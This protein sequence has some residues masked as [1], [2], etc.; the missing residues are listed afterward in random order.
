MSSGTLTSRAKPGGD[1]RVKV[2]SD[3][4]LKPEATSRDGG[5]R[6][7]HLFVLM[8]LVAATASVMLSRQP[9]PAN[10]ILV[11]LTVMAAGLAGLGFYRTLAPLVSDGIAAGGEALGERSRAVLE[12]EKVLVLRSIKELEFDRAMGKVSARDFDE[13]AGRLRARAI[14]L[15]GQL[16]RDASGYRELI[17]RELQARL[18]ARRA[19]A[20]PAPAPAA[21]PVEARQPSAPRC[22]GCGTVNDSD[23]RFCKSCGARVETR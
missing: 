21:A 9:T 1:V 14:T 5:F 22:A 13:M 8:S 17:E 6:P 2:A 12:R 23:A 10:L 4:R 7:W 11:S 20:A 16:D 19:P 18:A 15:I 3:F